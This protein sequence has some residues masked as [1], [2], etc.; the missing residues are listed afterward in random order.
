MFHKGRNIRE[1]G[2]QAQ[3]GRRKPPPDLQQ[4]GRTEEQAA[5]FKRTGRGG[6]VAL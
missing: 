3:P 5:A 4:A 6:A 2:H 1:T